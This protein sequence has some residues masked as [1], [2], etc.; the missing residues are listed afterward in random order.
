ML[1]KQ[2]VVARVRKRQPADRTRWWRRVRLSSSR[3]RGVRPRIHCLLPLVLGRV[4][5]LLLHQPGTCT[6]TI[7]DDASDGSGTA[8]TEAI[9]CRK[10]T[11]DL[12]ES[13]IT[14]DVEPCF[15][16]D[17]I[18][19]LIPKLM[20]GIVPRSWP[21]DHPILERLS[22]PGKCDSRNKRVWKNFLSATTKRQDQRAQ[23][24]T[25]RVD[26]KCSKEVPLAYPFSDKKI[27]LVKCVL[28]PQKGN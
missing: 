12:K 4:P 13:A 24:L 5:D 15:D 28:T 7:D 22:L 26:Q 2:L 23:N 17:P 18:V 11:L 19:E 8:P 10:K 6:G 1:N 16:G 3:G 21:Q 20:R 14:G 27:Q 9:S 25:P